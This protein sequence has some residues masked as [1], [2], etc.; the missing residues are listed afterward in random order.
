MPDL[1]ADSRAIARVLTRGGYS[2]QSSKEL[3][4]RARQLAGLK[5]DRDRKGEVDRLTV[6][7][8]ERFVEAAYTADG[9]RGL[10]MQTLLL[11]GLRVSEFVALRI[12]DLSFAERSLTVNSGKG[13]K[14][15]TVRL[16]LELA[17][18]L[19]LHVAGRE[20]GRC[21]CPPEARPTACGASSSS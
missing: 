18:A 11:S 2:Y 8:Q 13:D 15:R 4:K 10:M 21:S 3:V 6:E 20:V 16:P 19:R 14:R 17:Q 7:D 9:Q 1:D 12:E 5:R